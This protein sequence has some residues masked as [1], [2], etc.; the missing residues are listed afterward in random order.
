MLPDPDLRYV[1]GAF[2]LV[3]TWFV[4]VAIHQA[5]VRVVANE[6]LAYQNKTSCAFY[7]RGEKEALMWIESR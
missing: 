3:E 1:R 5:E 2:W 7:K 6:I 4:I